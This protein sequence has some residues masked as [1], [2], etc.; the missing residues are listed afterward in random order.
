M[1]FNICNQVSD[2]SRN[3]L[4]IHIGLARPFPSRHMPSL[5]LIDLFYRQRWYTTQRNATDSCYRSSYSHRRFASRKVLHFMSVSAQCH[6]SATYIL[7]C[8]SAPCSS[9]I[10]PLLRRCSILV[11]SSAVIGPDSLLRLE[12]VSYWILQKKCSALVHFRASPLFLRPARFWVSSQ[13]ATSHE[14]E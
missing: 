3:T 13:G 1:S 9:E 14:Q 8:P 10:S 12:V 2:I 6:W 11:N 4:L 5:L 7:F